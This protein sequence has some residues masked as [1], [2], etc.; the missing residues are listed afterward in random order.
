[1]ISSDWNR[2][3]SL[4]FHF[5]GYM[6]S[7]GAWFFNT[8][9][10]TVSFYTAI[11]IKW[12]VFFGHHRSSFSVIELKMFAYHQ[13]LLPRPID[14][15]IATYIFSNMYKKYSK[16]S[17]STIYV[18]V[19]VWMCVRNEYFFSRQHTGKIMFCINNQNKLHALYEYSYTFSLGTKKKT[20]RN[21]VNCS[22]ID[23]LYYYLQFY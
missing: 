6:I 21:C 9:C 17:L 20:R 15:R 5:D 13:I 18:S 12:S 7:M 14:K 19:W 16:V 1:M 8:I 3:H 10:H 4:D 22:Q 23:E 2:T 11:D